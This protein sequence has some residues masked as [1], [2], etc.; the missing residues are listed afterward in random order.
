MA[1]RANRKKK[2]SSRYIGKLLK[3]AVKKLK[4]A[5]PKATPKVQARID[6]HIKV[7]K[8][9]YSQLIRDCREVWIIP[10]PNL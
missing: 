9:C 6:L 7:L 10:N 8:T 3:S 5:R 2:I 4:A 1:T